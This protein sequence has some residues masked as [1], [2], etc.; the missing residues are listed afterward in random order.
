MARK[1]FLIDANKIVSNIKNKIGIS[2]FVFS[3]QIANWFAIKNE[4]K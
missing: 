3:H 1:I 2:S 4:N